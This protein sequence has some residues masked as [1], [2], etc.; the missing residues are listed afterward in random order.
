MK[1]VGIRPKVCI[2]ALMLIIGMFFLME[3]YIENVA[4]KHG[5]VRLRVSKTENSTSRI[6][7]VAKEINA[8]GLPVL[9]TLINNA[10]LPFT[11][12]WLCN[13]K[14]MGI[15]H[16]VLFITTDDHSERKLKKDWPAVTA[17]TLNDLNVLNSDQEYSKAGYVRLMVRRTEII[18][19][20]LNQG[21]TML[22]FEVDC[23][24]FAN[25]VPLFEKQ[26][27]G[28]DMVGSV[29]SDRPGMVAAGFLYMLPT[30]G[31]IK[32]WKKLNN[33]LQK[34]GKQIQKLSEDET[35]SE[36]DNDQTYFNRL[37]KEKYAGIRINV[38][39]FDV[40][41]DGR[42][43]KLSEKERN[44]IKPLIVNNNWV[45]GNRL[46][47]HRAKKFHHWFWKQNKT[48]CDAKLVK[49]TVYRDV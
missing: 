23:L 42:W 30:N 21:I 10:Y 24:W 29:I 36:S 11:Y 2:A 38:L 27:K 43:Y 15:H 32:L 14:N 8:R 45:S 44:E 41:A 49:E 34:L 20:L 31:M 33:N 4:K 28:Y 19:A 47:I 6:V 18:L 22:L 13:T 39:P 26:V 17:V 48:E 12:S 3:I 1:I 25:P 35:I 16:Q 7:R 5:P 46:K 40:F 9:F 37:V